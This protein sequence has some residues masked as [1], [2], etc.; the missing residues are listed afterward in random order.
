MELISGESNPINTA[1]IKQSQ[2]AS[3][4]EVKEVS[5]EDFQNFTYTGIS[6]EIPTPIVKVSSEAMFGINIDGFIPN[7]NW[8]FFRAHHF[9]NF[10]P[11][12]ISSASYAVPNLVVNFEFSALPS[13]VH[14][15]V[16]RHVEGDI[17]IGLRITSNTA[18]SGNLLVSQASGITRYYYTEEEKYTGLRFLQDSMSP[19]DYAPNGFALID[20]SLNRHFAITPCRRDNTLIT[21]FG[22]KLIKVPQTPHDLSYFPVANQFLEDWLIFSPQTSIPHPD[23]SSIN[24]AVYFDWTRVKFKTPMLPFIPWGPD[25]IN[26]Q[27][28]HYSATFNDKTAEEVTVN[29]DQWVWSPGS[30]ATLKE[31]KHVPHATKYSSP[32]KLPNGHFATVVNTTQNYFKQLLLKAQP[33]RNNDAS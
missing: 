14:Y 13:M 21:D 19:I 7:L 30:T 18:Q 28:L 17:G 27:I 2:V 1:A 24:I 23:P 26:L 8:K 29:Y 4:L 25:D 5:P 16:S 33:R 22:Q 3:G 9:R 32:I 12:Q 20:L 10:F 31:L 15:L 6:I 11:V